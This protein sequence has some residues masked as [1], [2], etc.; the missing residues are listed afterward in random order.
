[1]F[2]WFNMIL[3][4]FKPALNKKKRKSNS[5]KD[6]LP[7]KRKFLTKRKTTKT[8]ILFNCRRKSKT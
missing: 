4:K 7:D 8:K 3:L 1:M 2:K 5:L 6:N